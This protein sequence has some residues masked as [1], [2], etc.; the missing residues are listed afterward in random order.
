MKEEAKDGMKDNG[1]AVAPYR[2]RRDGS[3]EPGVREYYQAG[4]PTIPR[5]IARLY[6]YDR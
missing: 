3:I 6:G 4:D 2:I 5:I 1:F